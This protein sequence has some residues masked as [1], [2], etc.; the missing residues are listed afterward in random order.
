MLVLLVSVS[1]AALQAVWFFSH[2]TPRIEQANAQLFEL[3]VETSQR[4][5]FSAIDKQIKSLITAA[6]E[7]DTNEPS[8]ASAWKEFD[9]HFDA[10]PLDAVDT[11][12]RQLPALAAV[13][14]SDGRAIRELDAD[15]ARLRALYADSYKDL[16]VDLRHPPAFLWPTGK[17]LGERSGYRDAA[18]LNRAL[19]LA[20]TGEIGTARVMLA[21]LNATVDNPRVLASVYYTQGR[22]QFELFRATSEAEYYTQSIQSLRQSLVTKPDLQIAQRL[23][24]FLLSLPELAAAP[25]AAEGQ[26]EAPSEG[27]GA[28]VSEEIRIF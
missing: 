22:L 26:P 17:L 27:E 3:S 18:T 8:L 15:L 9:N 12:V 2:Y 1:V 19:F 13:E 11:L 7:S 20:Q 23:L 21:G 24:D 14:H 5:L 4:S 6:P 28:A 10:A 16:L 25:Q